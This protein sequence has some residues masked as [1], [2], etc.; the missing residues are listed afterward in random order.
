[1]EDMYIVEPE[2]GSM[3]VCN[4]IVAT[5]CRFECLETGLNRATVALV[6]IVVRWQMTVLGM[7]FKAVPVFVG[8]VAAR[9]LALPWARDGV[10]FRL[11][12][13][14]GLF[15]ERGSMR[16]W[17]WMW[18]W[19]A[20][21][22][23]RY[24]VVRHFGGLV[25]IILLRHVKQQLLEQVLGVVS[26]KRPIVLSHWRRRWCDGLH[27]ACYGVA[28]YRHVVG[29]TR[30]EDGL[31]MAQVACFVMLRKLGEIHQLDAAALKL[32]LECHLKGAGSRAG[33]IVFTQR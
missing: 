28:G 12:H 9:H 19:G 7:V 6:W 25:P 20:E 16:I 15:R 3:T 32:A 29:A 26:R 8:L 21:W 18:M 2:K 33:R 23:R 1:M 5:T 27:D 11:R 4:M 31:I 14:W 22:G 10:E 24:I 13:F 30:R 17:M